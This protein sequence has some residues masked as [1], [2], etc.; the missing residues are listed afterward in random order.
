MMDIR[1]FPPFAMTK[2]KPAMKIVYSGSLGHAEVYL[3]VIFLD[4]SMHTFVF[5]YCPLAFQKGC[6][7]F[8]FTKHI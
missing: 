7:D 3:R 6:V 2:K 8:Y 1:L 4:K 5:K